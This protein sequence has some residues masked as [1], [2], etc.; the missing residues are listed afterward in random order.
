MKIFI[1]ANVN[2]IH[3]VR[4]ADALANRDIEIFFFSLSKLEGDNPFKDI[5]NIQL[6]TFSFE[7]KFTKN[8]NSGISKWRYLKVLPTL[9]EKIRGFNPDILHAHYISGYGTL[10]ALSGFH[11]FVASVWGSDIFDFPNKSLL[12]KKL[13]EFNLKRA[14]K[15]LSTSK[16][17]AKETNKYT[18][19]EVLVTPFGIDMEQFR[20]MKVQSIFREE[21]IVI[22][23][24]KAMEIEYGID[25]LVKSFKKLSD[26]YNK[27][28]LKLLIV[29]GGNLEEELQQLVINL[30]LSDKT[31]STGKVDFKDIPK[32]H[33]MLSIFVA[34]SNSESFGV[35][36][37]EASACG[38]PVIV[39]DVGGLP[40]VVE[41]GITGFI[42]PPKDDETAM[43]AMEKLIL[44]DVLRKKLG[45]NG[46][47]R[48]KEYFNWDDNVAQM[49]N[50]Y[51]DILK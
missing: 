25:T 36:I 49:I 34:L 46:R 21:D 13:I 29:G 48:V 10:G 44:D 19:K 27:L 42:V 30:H 50:I 17:M 6:Y 43:I 4:W 45:K 11:P 2:S 37:I 31:V 24:I 16:I 40:E 1:L 3:A 9:K 20:P 41:D 15:I 12:H 18:D 8:D 5:E 7:E 51:K 26:K 22:G 47:K 14:D 32:Y 39:S 35:A 28:P 33:N 38:I 23:T